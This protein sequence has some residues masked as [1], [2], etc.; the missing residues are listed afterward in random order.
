MPQGP[1]NDLDHR[2]FRFACDAYDYCEELVGLGGI[3]PRIGYQLFDAASSVGANRE[4][5]KSAYSRREFRSKNAISLKESR[6]ASFWLRVAQAKCL[7]NAKRRGQL[8]D[9]S[10]QLIS[11]S[12]QPSGIFVDRAPTSDL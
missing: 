9:E 6:E 2:T 12:Q 7:G 5:A 10:N 3:A 11:I 1:P 4:E 8:L